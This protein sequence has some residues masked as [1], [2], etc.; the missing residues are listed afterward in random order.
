MKYKVLIETMSI[1]AY[2]IEADSVEDAEETYME[3]DILY[4]KPKQDEIISVE[5]I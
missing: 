3:G 4:T 2:S 5:A 1:E